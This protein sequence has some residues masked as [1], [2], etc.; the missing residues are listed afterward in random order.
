MTQYADTL[1]NRWKRRAADRVWAPPSEAE[2]NARAIPSTAVTLERRDADIWR[3][4]QGDTWADVVISTV[5]GKTVAG[6]IHGH[7]FKDSDIYQ[8]ELLAA[9]RV[10]MELQK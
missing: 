1:E 6:F 4:R 5:N 3:V 7:G 10:E 2:L 9:A 8:F